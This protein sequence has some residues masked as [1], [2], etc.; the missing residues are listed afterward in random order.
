MWNMNFVEEIVSYILMCL[1]TWLQQFISNI[2]ITQV[3]GLVQ[4]NKSPLAS[5]HPSTIHK[6]SLKNLMCQHRIPS[7]TM[8][9]IKNPANIRN[10]MLN[11]R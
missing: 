8:M 6:E 3:N 11:G 5:A 9:H 4:V 10:G 1:F 7:P 2:Y